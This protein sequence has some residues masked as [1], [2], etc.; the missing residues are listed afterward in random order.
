MRTKKPGHNISTFF[1]VS[2]NIRNIDSLSRFYRDSPL[3]SLSIA[4][5]DQ[6]NDPAAITRAGQAAERI[7]APNIW[8]TS[9]GACSH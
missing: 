4:G 3:N 1:T 9:G 7:T 5:S 8:S 2:V 6:T